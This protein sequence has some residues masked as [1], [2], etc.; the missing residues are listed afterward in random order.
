[1]EAEIKKDTNLSSK[2]DLCRAISPIYY[3]GKMCG[4]V[5]VRFVANTTGGFQARPN[6]FDLLYR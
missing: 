1:M 6:I 5:P 4:L 3:L 2:S